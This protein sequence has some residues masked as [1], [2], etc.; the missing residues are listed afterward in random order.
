MGEGRTLPVMRAVVR[1]LG[2]IGPAAASVVPLLEAA[3]AT[4][5]RLSHESGWRAIDA[6]E[7][8]RSE[9]IDAL[10]RIGER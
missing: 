4:D 2:E 7:A 10:A 6:D 9:I 1:S 5:R 8:F 3:S